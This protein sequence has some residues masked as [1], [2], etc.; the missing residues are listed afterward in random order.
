MAERVFAVT[1]HSGLKCTP[2]PTSRN[3]STIQTREALK[4]ALSWEM[5]LLYVVVLAG[6]VVTLIGGWFAVRRVVWGGGFRVVAQILAP[7]LFALGFV[8]IL[9][10]LIGI[11]YKVIADATHRSKP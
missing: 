8:G 2:L 7:V 4:Y 6:Y 10:G 9:A 11:G 1:E 5:A 3:M